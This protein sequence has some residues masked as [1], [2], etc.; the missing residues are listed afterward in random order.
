LRDL[1]RFRF[2]DGLADLSFFSLRCCKRF[3]ICMSRLS[4][5]SSS[6]GASTSLAR[7]SFIR[8]FCFL[9]SVFSASASSLFILPSFSMSSSF[10]L[11]GSLISPSSLPSWS[12]STFSWLSR[13]CSCFFFFSTLT[14][15]SRSILVRTSRAIMSSAFTVVSVFSFAFSV[16]M[17]RTNSLSSSSS[18]LRPV[19]SALRSSLLRSSRPWISASISKSLLS[20]PLARLGFSPTPPLRRFRSRFFSRVSRL[21][22]ARNSIRSRLRW[23]E[24]ESGEYCCC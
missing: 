5:S 19:T 18:A 1:R 6:S 20:S 2:G 7:Y 4:S 11:T 22:S 16:D 15:R 13:A 21:S 8:F 14:S 24:V 17:L 23:V 10:A 9:N 12:S 3:L